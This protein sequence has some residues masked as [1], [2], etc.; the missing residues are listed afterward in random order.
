MAA[1]R[2]RRRRRAPAV[3]RAQAALSKLRRC[4]CCCCFQGTINKDGFTEEG[5]PGDGAW[6]PAMQP[7]LSWGRAGGVLLRQRPETSKSMALILI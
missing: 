1:A 6:G 3:C 7:H 4:C 5:K 2:R